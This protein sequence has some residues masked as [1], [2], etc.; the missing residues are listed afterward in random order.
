MMDAPVEAP[1]GGPAL[2]HLTEVRGFDIP[3]SHRGGVG[4]AITFLKRRLGHELEPLLRELLT[5]QVHFNTALAAL[6]STPGPHLA[7][8]SSAVLLPLADPTRWREPGAHA[9]WRDVLLE[10]VLHALSPLLRAQHQWNLEIL[11]WLSEAGAA[12]P[13]GQ[14]MGGERLDGLEARCDVLAGMERLQGLRLG[15][16]LWREMLRR[17]IAFNHACVRALRRLSGTARPELA[18]P[19]PE[20]YAAWCREREPE[21]RARAAAAVARLERRPLL[22]LI[23]PAY[24]TPP[25]VLRACIES[26]QAQSYPHWQLCLVDDGSRD[27]EVRRIALHYARADA[28][29]R[30]ERLERNGGIALAT[31]AALA[32]ATGEYV[33]F[34]DHDDVLA[35]HALAEV[36]QYLEAHPDTD[37]LYTDEDKIDAGGRRFNPAFKPGPSPDLLRAVN[38]ICHFLVVRASLV[39]EVGGVRTGFEG[40]QDHDLVLRLLERTP[41]FAHLPQVLYHWRTLPGSTSLDS[42]AKPA[43]SDAGRRAVADHLRRLGEEAWVDV[44]SPGLYRVRYPARGQPL[45]SL[46]LVPGPASDWTEEEVRGVVTRTAW[47]RLEVLRPGPEVLQE[48]RATAAANRLAREARG[49][50]LVFLRSGYVPSEPGWLEELASQALRPEVG[51]VGARLV[52]AGGTHR[53]GALWLGARGERVSAFAGLPDPSL[54][55]A[56][57]SHWTRNLLAVSGDCMALRREVFERL[58]RFDEQQELSGGDVALC[59]RAVGEGLRVLYTP[60]ARVVRTGAWPAEAPCRACQLPVPHDPFHNPNLSLGLA[61]TGGVVLGGAETTR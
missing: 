19:S 6:L 61:G 10:P 20:D 7:Q 42:S 27:P 54:T 57:G 4:R 15:G 33:G 9:L 48:P 23:T 12:W 60:H 32:L 46:V 56:G 49:E 18:M 21:A 50:V 26:V 30:F 3:P 39:R 22:S 13:P 16:P 11:H 29:I 5:P 25:D 2:S 52:E 14:G 45:V 40:A 44:S 53:G 37:V 38:Y 59:L 47:P 58:G 36:V 51:V 28:R 34:L 17:Q 24:Q 1:R 41:R 31:N 43:A 55:A 8:R 35:P